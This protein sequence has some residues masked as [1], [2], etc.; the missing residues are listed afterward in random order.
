MPPILLLS[1]MPVFVNGLG[2]REGLA[3]LLLGHYGV[4]GEPALLAAFRLFVVNG[5]LLGVLAVVPG[6]TTLLRQ[7]E[8]VN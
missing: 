5:L 6:L 4:P 3:I 7:R 1:A 2:G 8:T